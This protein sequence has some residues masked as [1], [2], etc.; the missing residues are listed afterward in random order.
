MGVL[1]CE[2]LRC[3]RNNGMMEY[4]NVDFEK[5]KLDF[6]RGLLLFPKELKK[7]NNQPA[8]ALP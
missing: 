8:V 3:R 2:I 4:W 1:S 5:E 7:T 6:Q